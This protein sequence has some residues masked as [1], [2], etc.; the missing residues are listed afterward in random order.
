MGHPTAPAVP[1]LGKD[2]VRPSAV[3]P[4][5]VERTFGVDEIIVSK[6]DPQGRI[7]Y[8]NPVFVRVSAYPEARLLGKPHSIVRHPDMPRVVKLLWDTIGAGQEAAVA[9]IGQ[10][11]DVIGAMNDQVS[12]I[13]QALSGHGGLSSLAEALHTDITGFAAAH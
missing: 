12:G 2:T 6:T 7:T 4:T 10:I 5:G 13:Q 1:E 9:S 8:A 3:T 11:T